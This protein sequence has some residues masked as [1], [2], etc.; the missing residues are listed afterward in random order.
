[1]SLLPVLGFAVGAAVL[2]AR[3]TP[4]VLL[5]GC[6]ALVVAGYA[7]LVHG[8][9]TV[10]DLLPA[11]VAV[12]L[13]AGLAM[14]GTPGGLAAAGLDR[15]ARERITVWRAGR[16]GHWVAAVASG[17]VV[18]QLAVLANGF[19]PAQAIPASPDRAV[20]TR[21]TAG[22]RALG[23][24]VA[25]PGRSRPGSLAG[26]PGGGAPGRGRRRAAR[27]RPAAITSFRRSA[28]RAV[29]MR[30]FSAIIV[31]LNTDLNGFPADLNRYY[32]R[33][34]QMLLSGVPAAWFRPVTGARV[35]PAW[36]WLRRAGVLRRRG[37]PARRSR[38]PCRPWRRPGG[39]R[40][41]G[42]AS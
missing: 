21:L 38:P 41:S 33:C 11:Y 35:R 4:L 6:A 19:R 17:L 37:Q 31:E 42:G 30:Q 26:L 36:V 29:A 32:R 5:A 9:G 25:V 24:T 15:L 16:A 7:A 22:V 28:A 12:A 18:A 20:G 13:L 14:G 2:G 8:G 27:Q 1:M 10:N 34:P 40:P 3:R 39:P 23:G